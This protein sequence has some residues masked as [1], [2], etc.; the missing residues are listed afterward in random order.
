MRK[1]LPLA[2]IV[3]AGLLLAACSGGAAPEG[4]A[5]SA[6][7]ETPAAGGDLLIGNS[8][9]YPPMSFLP[10]GNEDPEA[11]QGFDIDLARAIAGELGREAV[12]EQQPYE[13]YLPS[14]ATG[15]LDIVM[16]AMQDL[17]SRRETVDFVDYMVTGPQLFTTADRTDLTSVEDLCGG[18]VV[19]DTGDVGYR[20]TITE[21]SSEVCA[22]D[23]QIEIV[24]ANGTADAILQLDQGRAD[25]TIR[26]AEAIR[27]LMDELSPGTYI[28]VGDPLAEIPV[29]IAVKKD[30]TELLN[31]IADALEALIADGTY[32]EIAETWGLSDLTVAEV[33]INGEPRS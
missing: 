13:Q 11:R 20:D 18:S 32:D 17:E 12:F 29:G 14:L 21:V 1:A 31:Q 3:T 7:P 5:T 4:D 24:P 23:A 25:A 33:T 19:L 10:E 28:T 8:A 30:N 22:A 26:G 16:S 27:Y 15:R 9:V 6:A 2:A